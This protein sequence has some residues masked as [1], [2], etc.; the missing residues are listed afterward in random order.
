MELL[1]EK[2]D[3]KSLFAP[4]CN[5]YWIRYSNAKGWSDLNQRAD[6]M[7][8]FA[9]AEQRRQRPVLLNCGDHDPSG[10]LISKTLRRGLT[11]LVHAVE[12]TYGVTWDPATLIV[13]RFGLNRDFIDA[14]HLTWIDG[15]TTG[16]NQDLADPAHRDHD[17]AYVEEYIKAHGARKVEANALVV[18]AE[19]GRQLLLDTIHKYIAPDALDRYEARLREPREAL[20]VET[21]R[22]LRH[23]AEGSR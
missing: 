19:A 2:V 1:V 22:Q 21:L 20:R 12:Q 10:L 7:C 11:T 17:K 23:L 5:R 15:L 3:L 6:M 16:S 8:R 4:V 18:A 9:A 13:D 14:H